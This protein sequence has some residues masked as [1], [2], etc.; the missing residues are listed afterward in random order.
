MSALDNVPMDRIGGRAHRTDYRQVALTILAG[1]LY[2]AGWL[3][4]RACLGAR[5][6]GAWAAYTWAGSA[7][8]VGFDDGY[9]PRHSRGK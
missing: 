5:I 4:G 1:L 3:P 9:N 6:V 2:I 7:V 8:R